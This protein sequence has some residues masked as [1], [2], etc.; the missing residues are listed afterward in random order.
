MDCTKCTFKGCRAS[1]P[2]VDKSGEYL[3]EYLSDETQPYVKTASSLID[4]GRAGTLT[5]LDEIIEF[6]KTRGYQKVGVAYCYGMENQA[7]LLR[8]YLERSGLKPEMVSCTVD[9]LRESQ[10][11]PGKQANAVSC[12][13][14]GQ[15]HALKAAGVDF[16]ILMGL[17]LGHDI[18]LQKHLDMDFTTF[19]VKDRVLNHNPLLALTGN[20]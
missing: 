5:R 4:N 12:N 7:K 17:C 11:A 6:V 13:P 16:A 2:C 9:G 3:E 15:A 14:L 18:L 10:I 19:V 1:Q 20:S 8:E